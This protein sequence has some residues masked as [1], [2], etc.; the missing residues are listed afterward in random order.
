MDYRMKIIILIIMLCCLLL[1]ICGS[2]DNFRTSFPPVM[3]VLD[4]A[5]YPSHT[6]N[7]FMELSLFASL[8]SDTTVSNNSHIKISVSCVTVALFLH[9]HY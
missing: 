5:K 2:G 8:C 3:L 1:L 4:R 7:N 6:N 9:G